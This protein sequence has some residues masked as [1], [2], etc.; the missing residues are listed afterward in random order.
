LPATVR[1][2]ELT[3]VAVDGGELLMGVGVG[4]GNYLTN[5]LWDLGMLPADERRLDSFSMF[6]TPASGETE[7]TYRMAIGTFDGPTM[8]WTGDL[9]TT[10]WQT[11]TS[12]VLNATIDGGLILDPNLRHIAYIVGNGWTVETSLVN[13]G[14]GFVGISFNTDSRMMDMDLRHDRDVAMRASFSSPIAV[15]EP[16]TLTMLALGALGLVLQFRRP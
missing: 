11:T 8:R 12:T 1:A 14:P 5:S 3:V 2:T 13:Q 7:L 16:S 9:F 10:P 4:Y 6:V 15:P